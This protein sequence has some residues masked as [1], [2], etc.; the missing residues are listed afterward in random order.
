MQDITLYLAISSLA[1]SAIAAILT[2]VTL[3]KVS[4]NK[5]DKY[6]DSRVVGELNRLRGSQETLGR[7]LA[8]AQSRLSD[9]SGRSVMDLSKTLG[10][11]VG[12]MEESVN[13]AQ[14]NLAR[15]NSEAIGLMNRAITEKLDNADRTLKL[16]TEQV[17]KKLGLLREENEKKLAEIR[18]TVDEKLQKTLDERIARSFSEVS[19]RLE[20]VYTSLGEMN[21]LT[22]D[23]GDL[24]N[25]LSNV[26]TRGILGEIQLGA[27]LEQILSPEQYA[28]N[29]VTVPQSK[30]PVEFAVKLPGPEDGSSVW[31]PIDSKFPL[32]CYRQL[33]D[34][35]EKGDPAAVN[36]AGALLEQRLKSFAKDIRDKYV[37]APWTTDFAIMFLPTE[38]LYAE[39]VR[40]GLVETLQ[41]TCKVNI[42]G[43][44]TM[45]ALLNSLQMGFRTLAVQK[46]SGEVWEVLGA[47]KTEFAA[48]EKVLTAAQARINQANSE[49]DKLVGV[50]TRAINR[51]LREVSALPAEKAQGLLEDSD[52]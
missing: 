33:E 13:R 32:D 47:V 17:D 22:R 39:A 26:K 14:A 27:I 12:A 51:K 16:M 40:R 30:N 8:D 49:L 5:K 18:Q 48:F 28:T 38:G 50:R 11:R 23:V 37:R 21:K 45:A 42:A 10:D 6:D 24:K 44:T 52:E 2:L 7:T 34:A 25:V 46:R 41:N 9:A 29:V 31:L 3:I 15:T 4:A 20:Q 19:K 43:P 1:L 35:Y 36:A